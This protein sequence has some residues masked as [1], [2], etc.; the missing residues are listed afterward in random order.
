MQ[1]AVIDVETAN[2]DQG[3]ICQIGVVVFED[4]KE[5]DSWSTLV[6][7]DTWFHWMNID[8]HGI[9]EDDVKDSLSF[10]EVSSK[11]NRYLAESPVVVSHTIFDKNALTQA[12]AKIN[13]PPP[14]CAWLDSARVARRTWEQFAYEGYGLANLAAYIKFEFQHHD[15]LEDAR[16]SGMILLAAIK[17]SGKTIEEWL[18]LSF[19]PIMQIH[20]PDN[21][22]LKVIKIEGNPDGDLFGEEVVFTGKL[23]VIRREIAAIAAEAGCYVSPTIRKKTITMLVVGS[24]EPATLRGNKISSK[25]KKVEQLAKQGVSI[26]IMTE[27]DFLSLIRE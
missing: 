11:L 24:F 2:P 10:L 21:S 12:F 4:G 27:Q 19:K 8:I 1:F 15:A 3:S 22:Y 14:Q 13:M 5:V 17:E 20:S 6:N 18:Q 16:A 7:P 9:D 26:R 23:S 25:Q